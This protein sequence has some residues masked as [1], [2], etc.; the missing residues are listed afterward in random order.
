[1]VADDNGNDIEPDLGWARAPVAQPVSGKL[2]EPHLLAP[3]DRLGRLTP[4][5]GTAS[6]DLAEHKKRTFAGDYVYLP[7]AA[8]IVAID[9]PKARPPVY[10]YRGRL[11]SPA[12]L[13]ARI[14][15]S[16]M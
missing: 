8:P 3:V 15:R 14:H 13:G 6:L 5:V 7:H 12:E 16:G 4:A 1:V 11:T 9:Y 2:L 10:I